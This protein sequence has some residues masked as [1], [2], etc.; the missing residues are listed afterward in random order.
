MVHI[1]Q[2]LSYRILLNF[3]FFMKILNKSRLLATL[4]IN[5]H[6]DFKTRDIN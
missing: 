1:L 4:D 3:N 5:Y 6:S 2:N